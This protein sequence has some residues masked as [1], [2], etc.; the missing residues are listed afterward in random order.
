MVSKNFKSFADDY[1]KWRCNL[2]CG[3]S[4]SL[5][6]QFFSKMLITI[7][8]KKQTNKQCKQNPKTKQQPKNQ[9]K[10]QNPRKKKSVFLRHLYQ[11]QN[12]ITKITRNIA[13]NITAVSQIDRRH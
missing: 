5:S 8:T 10:Q 6:I 3:Y 9:T 1:R 2:D 13:N 7:N 11:M 4:V 12:L